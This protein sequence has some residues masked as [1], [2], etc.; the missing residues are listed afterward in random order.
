MTGLGSRH[1]SDEGRQDSGDQGFPVAVGE[2]YYKVG[3]HESVWVVKR[4]FNPRASDIPH[5]VIE[6]VG[7]GSG[8]GL[9]SLTTLLDTRVYRPDRRGQERDEPTPYHRRRWDTLSRLLQR[10]R[11]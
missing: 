4:I 7:G 11:R 2:R 8:S 1:S 6:Q 5:A 10:A 3:V 9:I